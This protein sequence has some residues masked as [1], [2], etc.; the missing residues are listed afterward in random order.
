MPIDRNVLA[1]LNKIQPADGQNF[2]KKMVTLY[3]TSADNNIKTLKKAWLD[4]DIELL[5]RSAHNLKSSSANLGVTAL[6]KLS[7]Q[8]ELDCRRNI[9]TDIDRQIDAVTKEFS[10]VSNYL[11]EEIIKS[12]E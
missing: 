7:E 9:L 6:T 8:L 11:S 5:T 2:M 10:I 12:L 3:L 1:T 4:D